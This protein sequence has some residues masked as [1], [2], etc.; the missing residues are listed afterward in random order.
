MIGIVS[1]EIKNITWDDLLSPAWKNSFK[2]TEQR[3]E[4]LIRL[5]RI[6]FKLNSSK[7]ILHQG[8]HL[9]I[10]ILIQTNAFFYH[11][12]RRHQ[13]KK[14]DM[15]KLS[16]DIFF[17][18]HIQREERRM[19]DSYFVHNAHWR[20]LKRNIT[21]YISTDDKMLANFRCKTSSSLDF[22]NWPN[23]MKSFIVKISI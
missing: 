14:N 9:S 16:Q 10:S 6:E 18:L 5:Q 21:V 20:R 19:S 15:V 7:K 22:R 1:E 8:H 3:L 11:S 12:W 17:S 13:K 23:R 4:L 2:K